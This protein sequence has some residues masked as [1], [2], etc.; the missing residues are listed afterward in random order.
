VKGERHSE[1]GKVD[2]GPYIREKDDG[3]LKKGYTS[4]LTSLP[5]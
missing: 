5:I 3:C 4:L 1:V 2:L